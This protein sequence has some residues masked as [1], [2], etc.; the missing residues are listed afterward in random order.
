M[1]DNY[2]DFHGEF[3]M[4]PTELCT[5]TVTPFS[6]FLS[7]ENAEAIRYVLPQYRL[8]FSLSFSTLFVFSAVRRRVDA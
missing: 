5:H 6:V 1:F 4:N 8:S 3:S 7:E 2:Y